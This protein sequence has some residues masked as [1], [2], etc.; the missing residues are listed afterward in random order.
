LIKLF[1]KSLVCEALHAVYA[2]LVVHFQTLSSL[3]IV[4][5]LTAILVLQN[6]NCSIW[7]QYWQV[8]KVVGDIFHIRRGF[9]G[10]D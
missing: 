6:I 9:L 7:T 2:L 3:F 5:A 1:K 8:K 10:T 4:F